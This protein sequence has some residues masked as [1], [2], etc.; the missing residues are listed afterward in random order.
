VVVASSWYLRAFD[1]STDVTVTFSP[2][3]LSPLG[4]GGGADSIGGTYELPNERG[5]K[6]FFELSSGAANAQLITPVP[7]DWW[8]TGVW[9]SNLLREGSVPLTLNLDAFTV[10]AL[11]NTAE[12]TFLTWDGS[13]ES[14]WSTEAA[15]STSAVAALNRSAGQSS[16]GFVALGP[17]I[18]AAPYLGAFPQLQ[19]IPA[20]VIRQITSGLG[21]SVYFTPSVD[22]QLGI[23]T[24]QP[25]IIRLVNGMASKRSFVQ[26]SY[27]PQVKVQCYNTSSLVNKVIYSS[28]DVIQVTSGE[29]QEIRVALDGTPLF[30]TL[31]QPT[32]VTAIPVVPYLGP[33]S[34][35]CVYDSDGYEASGPWKAFGGRITVQ[36]GATPD[37]MLIKITAP[38]D[39][40]NPEAVYSIAEDGN[41]ALYITAGQAAMFNKQ[42]MVFGTGDLVPS[43]TYRPS[44]DMPEMDN[45]LVINKDIAYSRAAA[46]IAVVSEPQLRMED[47]EFDNAVLASSVPGNEIAISPSVLA[48]SK[49]RAHD[50]MWRFEALTYTQGLGFSGSAVQATTVGDFDDS[51]LNMTLG[52]FQ[53]YLAQQYPDGAVPTIGNAPGQFPAGTD[54][55]DA[56]LIT[57]AP[58]LDQFDYEPLKTTGAA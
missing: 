37:E 54:L 17:E 18:N 33:S 16:S 49:F 57:P 45:P 53:A 56:T 20:D 36:A 29:D 24:A 4:T 44:A 12:M 14:L 8:T 5:S 11:D 1:H 35:Y 38:S 46:L 43:N 34:I 48:V 22:S 9:D 31:I 13:P 27:V 40:G 10:D 21:V 51:F 58:T 6:V 25:S 7:T 50:A 39:P 30:R 55:G 19:G 41:P 15:V 23:I 32:T 28:P 3:D 47:V 52:D 42:E 26:P 2:Y